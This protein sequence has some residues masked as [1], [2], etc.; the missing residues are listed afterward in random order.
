VEAF[1]A[2]DAACRHFRRRLV[3]VRPDHAGLGT[4]CTDWSVRDLLNH[5]V[6]GQRRYIMLLNGATTVEVEATRD[7]DHLGTDAVAAF[8]EAHAELTASFRTPGALTRIVHH[9]GGDRTGRDLLLMRT[10]EY[11]VHGWDLS[12]AIGVDDTI[13]G[14]LAEFL[15]REVTAAHHLWEGPRGAFAAPVTAPASAAAQDRLMRLT[16]RLADH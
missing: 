1:E 13:E 7:H 6:G 11:A 12:Q 16:G 15:A 14:D 10:V 2:L 3:I 4:P 9:R 8:D 5:M